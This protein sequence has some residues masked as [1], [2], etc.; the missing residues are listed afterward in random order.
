MPLDQKPEIGS[1]E[2]AELVAKQNDQFRRWHTIGE[3]KPG[4]F[5]P[6]RSVWTAS[7]D[8]KEPDF[9]KAALQAIGALETFEADVKSRWCALPHC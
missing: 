8:A 1:Q 5:V 4:V 2:H 6:G 7:F 9:Q 3:R